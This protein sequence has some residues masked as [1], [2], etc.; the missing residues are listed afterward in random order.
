MG[1]YY[2]SYVEDPIWQRKFTII[3][4]SGL[5]IAVAVSL[6]SLIISLRQGRVFKGITGISEITGYRSVSSD[7][8]K[9]LPP[10]RSRSSRRLIGAWN[11]LI[12]TTYWSLPK[13]ELN[14]GQGANR[15]RHV[16][17]SDRLTNCIIFSHNLVGIPCSRTGLR[18]KGCPSHFKPQSSW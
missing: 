13:L 18:H 17:T 12:S 9:P 4:C 6:P 7:D 15:R 1:C 5:A 3:W 10:P 8:N 2:S 11:A 16:T 14:L